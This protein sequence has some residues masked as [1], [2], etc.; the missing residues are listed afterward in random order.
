[1]YGKEWAINLRDA[2]IDWT[3]MDIAGYLLGLC[4][5]LYKEEVLFSTQLKHVFWTDNSIGNMLTR[6]LMELAAAGVLEHDEE[7]TRVRW[8]RTFKGSWE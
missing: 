3:D 7:E 2:L 4:L 6:M 8:R 5:G 1:M